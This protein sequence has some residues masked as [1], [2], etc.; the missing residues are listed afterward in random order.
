LPFLKSVRRANHLFQ[1]SLT[2]VKDTQVICLCNF[3]GTFKYLG[4]EILSSNLESYRWMT[5][6]ALAYAKCGFNKKICVLFFEGMKFY[7]NLVFHL[8]LLFSIFNVLFLQLCLCFGFLMKMKWSKGAEYT[9]Y[10]NDWEKN[11]E[12]TK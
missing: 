5:W 8:H 9:F 3:L 4:L 6:M 7:W 10:T 11:A 2:S 12:K 1:V